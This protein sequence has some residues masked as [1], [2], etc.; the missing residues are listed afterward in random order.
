MSASNSSSFPMAPPSAGVMTPE[1]INELARG[2]HAS[3]IILTAYELALFTIIGD[4]SMRS[5][6][7]ARLIDAD[8]RATDRL[9]NALTAIGLLEKSNGLFANT[10]V[11]GQC[12]VKGQ[13]GYLAGLMHTVN[14]WDTWSTLTEAV[15]RGTAA[16][17]PEVNDRGGGWLKAFIAA[18]HANAVPRSAEVVALINLDNVATVLD[19]G[20]GSGAYAVAFALAK[21]GLRA[22]VFDLPNV[23]SLTREYV[24]REGL[25]ARVS[26][27]AGD[28]NRDEVGRGYDLV[29]LSA[30]IHSNSP[31][32][33]ESL[34]AKCARALNRGGRLI[35]QDFIIDEMR[36]S[37]PHAAIFALNML[38]ATRAGDTY[39]ENEVS[40]WM[41]GAGLGEI[42]SMDTKMGTSLII[43]K[44]D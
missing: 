26:L 23:I 30:I 22:T 32:E 17:T 39:T 6:E 1:C 13:P 37:P 9:M 10:L 21:S 16:G 24:E 14:L 20:G 7:V 34:I 35:I 43:G 4:R 36:T 18:M 38:V 33:N 5:S 29:F 42:Q 15:R 19:V 25:S 40:G 28:Y 27:L 41:R 2:F 8:E 11:A 44:L 12:L 31:Q 3:R